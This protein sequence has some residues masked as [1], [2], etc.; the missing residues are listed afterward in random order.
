M[1]ISTL[2][3]LE[4]NKKYNLIEN[5]D[6]REQENPEG[7]GIDIRVGKIYRLIG[8]GFLGIT[9]RKSADTEKI[10][11]IDKGDKEVTIKPGD[12]LLTKTIEKFNV[13]GEKIETEEG[14]KPMFISLHVYPRSTLQ[15]CGIYLM[16]TKTD[17]GYVGELT[18]ALAN[19][20]DK[21]FRIELGARFAN[22]V[23]MQVTGDIHRAYEGQWK[24]GRVSSGG[25]EKQA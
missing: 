20:S 3:V 11:D 23:F 7:V 21:P 24:G 12:Y 10:A 1:I 17:P 6:E 19:L 25:V 15:R 8:E 16:A 18:F 4:L 22:I 9:D 13:P 2:K 14:A 5:L